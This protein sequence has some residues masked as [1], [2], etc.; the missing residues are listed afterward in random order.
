MLGKTNTMFVGAEES[1]DIQLIQENVLTPSAGNIEKIECVH[2]IY[3]AFLS[4]QKILYGADINNLKILQNG[5]SPLKASHIIFAD[6]KY[7]FTNSCSNYVYGTGDFTIFE[8]IEIQ[9]SHNLIGIYKNSGEKIVVFLYLKDE[10]PSTRVRE[11]MLILDSLDNYVPEEKVLINIS[12]SMYFSINEGRF[13]K[14]FFAKDRIF[15]EESTGSSNTT[16]TAIISMDGSKVYAKSKC[17]FLVHDFFYSNT[18]NGL[19]YSL[20]GVDYSLLGSCNLSGLILTEYEDN[21]I[22]IFYTDGNNYK[23]TIAESP[24]KIISALDKA[25]TVNILGTIM[26]GLNHLESTYL[27]CTGGVILKTQIDYSAGNTPDV[28]VIK[29]LSAKQA[30]MQANEYTDTKIKELKDYVDSL[31]QV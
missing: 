18:G 24:Q 27:G 21:M 9:P 16:S 28:T 22:G 30:L 8:E 29:T 3:F 7:Y 1:T 19:Y 17:N 14:S 23:F 13:R 31:I 25:I 20:N 10:Y 4:D 12:V 6:D 11:Y 26:T 5:S 15:I 2:D